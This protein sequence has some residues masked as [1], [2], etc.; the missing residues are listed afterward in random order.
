MKKI[1]L[2]II[3][4]SFIFAGCKELYNP[5]I[6]SSISGYLTV[7]GNILYGNDA[8][9]IK[10]SR[11]IGLKNLNK[12]IQEN[13]AYVVVE[14]NDNSKH[15]LRFI[16]NGSYQSK[17][18]LNKLVQYRINITTQNGNNYMSNFAPVLI[19]PPLKTSWEQDDN[20]VEIFA[21]TSDSSG[22][23]KYYMWQYDEDW[24][25]RSVFLSN[26]KFIYDDR[27]TLKGIDY[28]FPDQSYDTSIFRCWKNNLSRSILVADATSVNNSTLTFPLNKISTGGEKISVL[29]HT[30]IKQYAVSAQG[31]QFLLQMK[32]NTEQLGSIFDPQPTS[33]KSNV[34][35]TNKQNELVIGYVDVTSV[36]AQ[37]FFINNSELK[38]WRSGMSC[39]MAES[40]NNIDSIE[41]KLSGLTPTIP[42]KIENGRVTDLQGA[43]PQCVDCTLRGGIKTRP[44]YWPN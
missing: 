29:Y 39:I 21:N 36:S 38:N 17:L 25:I 37:N 7:E 4:L 23:T 22:N 14:G 13:N 31:Y 9:T 8:T 10:L 3:Y 24:E 35:C 19:T 40:E 32:K 34:F 16:G 27:N 28:I 2:L 5:N 6:A 43:S 30:A 12:I 41:K 44:P 26:L 11:S 42:V 20:G 15:P 18:I 1:Y 33:L